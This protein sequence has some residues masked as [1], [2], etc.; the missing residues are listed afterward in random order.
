MTGQLIA[1]DRAWLRLMASQPVIQKLQSKSRVNSVDSVH[2]CLAAMG[3]LPC[4]FECHPR[5]ISLRAPL[6]T[7]ASTGSLLSSRVVLCLLCPVWV[8]FTCFYSTKS[9]SFRCCCAPYTSLSPGLPAKMSRSQVI[10]KARLASS[11]YTPSTLRPSMGP[12]LSMSR[13]GLCFAKR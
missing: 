5:P 6:S 3:C 10:F 7:T 9:N 8:V 2:S 13:L 1:L 11:Q 4:I 12:T